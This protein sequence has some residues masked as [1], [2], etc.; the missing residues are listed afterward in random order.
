M[1]PFVPQPEERIVNQGNTPHKSKATGQ[2]EADIPNGRRPG[3]PQAWLFNLAPSLVLIV[4]MIALYGIQQKNINELEAKLSGSPAAS[5]QADINTG[6]GATDFNLLTEQVLTLNK[7]VDAQTIELD[8]LNKQLANGAP[9]TQAQP[10]PDPAVAQNLDEL[11]AKV[12]NLSQTLAS[13]NTSS[14]WQQAIASAQATLTQ[15]FNTRLETS[16]KATLSKQQ[17]QDSALKTLEQTLSANKTKLGELQ[18]T[19]AGMEKQLAA[20]EN[21]VNEKLAGIARQV[22]KQLEQRTLALNADWRK[23]ID[24]ATMAVKAD[25]NQQLDKKIAAQATAFKQNDT[26]NASLSEQKSELARLSEETNRLNKALSNTSSQV[27]NQKTEIASLKSS[28]AT[29][30]GIASAGQT[31]SLA[32]RQLNSA[33]QPLRQHLN[34]L[35]QAIVEATNHL[36]NQRQTIAALETKIGSQAA[37]QNTTSTTVASPDVAKFQG[38]LASFGTELDKLH[39]KDSQLLADLNSTKGQIKT[40]QGTVSKLQSTPV[41][42]TGNSVASGELSAISARLNDL[43][44]RLDS[45]MSQVKSSASDFTSWRQR[46]DSQLARQ[47]STSASNSGSGASD[48]DIAAIKETIRLLKTN[49]PYTKFPPLN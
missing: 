48:K 12:E 15:E 49:H 33:L 17:A 4:I 19:L 42:T 30:Q 1:E 39:D 29:V 34:T 44:I 23:D 25:F 24:S 5:G 16:N 18:G 46:I 43:D 27:D 37:T 45:T 28:L 47:T 32:T 21:S 35:E 26:L 8:A 6:N 36:A 3:K 41:A 22:D 38:Q 31:A 14:D 11:R 9:K 20:T 40:L 13:R 7:I 2:P 10:A